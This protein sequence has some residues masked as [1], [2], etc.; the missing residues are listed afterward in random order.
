MNNRLRIW[1]WIIAPFAIITG[2]LI[3]RNQGPLI[4]WFYIIAGICFLGISINPIYKRMN[5]HRA[6]RRTVL[7]STIVV[8]VIVFVFGCLLLYSRM[9]SVPG[10]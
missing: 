2:I 5:T 9:M 10:P 4:G 8:A 6:A 1:L 7:I 3:V